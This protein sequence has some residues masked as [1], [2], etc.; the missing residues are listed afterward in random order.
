MGKFAAAAKHLREGE[1]PM[2][3]WDGQCLT[4]AGQNG[5]DS[6]ALAEGALATLS[7]TVVPAAPASIDLVKKGV[8]TARQVGKMLNEA[9]SSASTQTQIEEV[10]IIE[11]DLRSVPFTMYKESAV[12]ALKKGIPLEKYEDFV[13]LRI[14]PRYKLPEKHVEELCD[15]MYCELNQ[16]SITEFAFQ[17]EPPEGLPEG[18]LPNSFTFC[19]MVVYRREKAPGTEVLDLGYCFFNVAFKFGSEKIVREI[20]ET[21]T[22]SV[23]R[24]FL[25][26]TIGQDTKTTQ[27]LRNVEEYR[28]FQMDWGKK[29]DIQAYFRFKAVQ[30][31]SQDALQ[32]GED[33]EMA[34]EHTGMSPIKDQ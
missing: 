19:R 10:K 11:Q 20:M 22:D 2:L 25:W 26:F 23:P 32:K 8:D 28:Q 29:E 24:K 9:L 30:S 21:K 4:K 12:V 18:E 16:V 31:L 7:Q 34:F 6:K 13:T 17:Q 15:S 33:T 14:A 27:T 1:T 5:T 3:D